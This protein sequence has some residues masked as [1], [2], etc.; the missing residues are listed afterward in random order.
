MSD[1]PKNFA[2]LETV[3]AVDGAGLEAETLGGGVEALSWE[4]EGIP[5]LKKVNITIQEIVDVL[6]T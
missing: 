4:S 3:L 1:P 6:N 5:F 2:A